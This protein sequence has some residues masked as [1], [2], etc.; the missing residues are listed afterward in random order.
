M[1]EENYDL[2]NFCLKSLRRAST[3]RENKAQSGGEKC[4]PEVFCEK[5]GWDS[6]AG[7][8]PFSK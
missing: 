5:V 8:I 6:M 3:V 2:T 7:S 4:V 1:S